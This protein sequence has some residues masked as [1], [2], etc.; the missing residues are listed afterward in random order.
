M[1]DT[2]IGVREVLMG[3]REDLVTLYRYYGNM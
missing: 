2:L 3:L 1:V